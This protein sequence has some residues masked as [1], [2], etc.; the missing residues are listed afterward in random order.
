MTVIIVHI[1][2]IATTDQWIHYS[3]RYTRTWTGRRDSLF[4][5]NRTG[6]GHITV[7]IAAHQAGRDAVRQAVRYAIRKA[8]CQSVCV[9]GR[10]VVAVAGLIRIGSGRF[11]QGVFGSGL[12]EIVGAGVDLKVN[13]LR[14]GHLKLIQIKFWCERRA[15]AA[16]GFSVLLVVVLERYGVRGD[17]YGLLLE[18]VHRKR[19]VVIYE[20]IKV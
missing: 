4:T 13:T 2:F 3:V 7:R 15:K 8:A 17:R 5:V 20:L 11:G 18:I 1:W 12:I 19:I 9:A 10:V 16:G 6:I 14:F